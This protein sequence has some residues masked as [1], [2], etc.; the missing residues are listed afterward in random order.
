MDRFLFMEEV[1]TIVNCYGTQSMLKTGL[2]RPLRWKIFD[3]LY[4]LGVRMSELLFD[5]ATDEKEA[6]SPIKATQ[7]ENNEE[8]VYLSRTRKRTMRSKMVIDNINNMKM[9]LSSKVTLRKTRK[10]KVDSELSAKAVNSA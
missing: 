10:T 8:V 3:K 7:Q 9:K 6:N 5:S 2:K 1:W 4:N